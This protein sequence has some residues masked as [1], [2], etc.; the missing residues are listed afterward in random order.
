NNV[1]RTLVMQLYHNYG[2]RHIQGFRYGFQGF[3]PSFKHETMNLNPESVQNVHNIGGSIL[4]SSRGPQ[5]I[6][7]IVD[8]LE[9]QDIRQLF[10][11]GGDG[12]LRGAHE[13]ALEVEKRNLKIG[14]LGIPKTID[15]DIPFCVK[16]FGF[17]TAFSKAVEAVQAAHAE[18]YGNNY[19]IVIIKLMGRDSGF[20]AANTSLA[21]P[22]V[23]FVLIPEVPFSLEGEN[24]F[25]N[26]LEK[27]LN[28]K[29]LDGRHPHSVIVVAEGVGQDLMGNTGEEK[30]ASGNI[31]Y[32]DISHFLKKQI[33]NHFEGKIP[34]NVKLI[35]PSYMIRS[36]PAN[37]H[38]AIFCYHLA[39]NAVHAMMCGKTDL[40][41][42]YWNGH[43]THVPLDSVVREKKRI[44][45]RGDFWRQVLFSTGQSR[46]MFFN[47][48][49]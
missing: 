40:I 45:P 13:I 37:P 22:D 31:R 11:I 42:G 39:D 47:P 25:L 3:I 38:D 17:E 5:D 14:I 33:L 46:E 48:K 28:K 23:N 29:Q 27:Y 21:C 43:F 4:S 18:A 20:I 24:G 36:L 7:E 1:I 10:C 30:D 26:C 2:V 44:D 15:N 6:G 9:R 12:T 8:C 34:V 41:I 19:G 49:T 16:T 35:E 32:K